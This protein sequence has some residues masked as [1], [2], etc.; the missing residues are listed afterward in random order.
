MALLV[1]PL[2]KG[3]L[4]YDTEKQELISEQGRACIPH[5]RGGFPVMLPEEARKL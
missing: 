3:N 4:R 2:T 5:P 1:C